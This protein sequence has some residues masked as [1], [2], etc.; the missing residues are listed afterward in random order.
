MV[1]DTWGTLIYLEE[2]SSNNMIGWNGTI[3]GKPA[4]NG[5]FFYQIIATTLTDIQI[6]R[7]GSFTLIR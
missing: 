3:D 6:K 2:N 7:N 5:N 1:F 4:E